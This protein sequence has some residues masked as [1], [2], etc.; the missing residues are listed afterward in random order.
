MQ[1]RGLCLALWCFNILKIAGNTKEWEILLSDLQCFMK[2]WED[3]AALAQFPTWLKFAAAWKQKL[4]LEG[5]QPSGCHS[6]HHS[7]LP[8]GHKGQRSWER[9]AR[10]L[11][12]T[13]LFFL[14]RHG[15][16]YFYQSPWIKKATWLGQT[17][18]KSTEQMNFPVWPIKPYPAILWV[19]GLLSRCWAGC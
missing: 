16:Q 11:P 4:L 9:L 6:P 1:P 12:N 5:T 14:S 15:V 13:F 7:W 10:C 2:K 17:S 19:Y 18:G 8:A 3:P